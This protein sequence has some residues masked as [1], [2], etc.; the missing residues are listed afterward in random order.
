[1]AVPLALIASGIPSIAKQLI[2]NKV[3]LKDEYMIP[4]YFLKTMKELYDQKHCYRDV[5]I[6]ADRY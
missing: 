3:R 4:S 6:L 2:S 1:M 5:I